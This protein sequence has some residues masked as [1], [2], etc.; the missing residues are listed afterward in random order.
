MSLNEI[1][2]NIIALSANLYGLITI[3]QIAPDMQYGGQYQFLTILGLTASTL[4]MTFKLLRY[5]S[6]SLFHGPY[7][8]LSNLATPV[9]GLISFLYWSMALYDRELLVPKDTPF[10]LPFSLDLA[11]HLWP[12]IFL[13]IDMFV[14]KPGFKASTLDVCSL[15]SFSVAYYFWVEHCFQKNKFYVYPFLALFSDLHRFIYFMVCGGLCSIM[16]HLG[17]YAHNIYHGQIKKSKTV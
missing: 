12:T 10:V 1:L 4:A 7:I 11:L 15:F 6:S 17:A 16:Y 3:H 9:E 14:F 5:L 2:F 13:Y 8:Y